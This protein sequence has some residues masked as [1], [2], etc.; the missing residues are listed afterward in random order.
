MAKKNIHTV[1]DELTAMVQDK[2]TLSGAF[3]GT[4]RRILS[5]YAN[6]DAGNS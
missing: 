5:R 4:P 6:E 1:M 3:R 2:S